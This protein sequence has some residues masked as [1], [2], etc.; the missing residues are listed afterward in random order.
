MSL[1][2]ELDQLK[3]SGLYRQLKTIEKINGNKVT[4]A[5]R[6]L[7]SFCSNDYL[8]LSQHPLV[9]EKANEAAK[10]FGFGA[11]A[12]RLISGQTIWHD[13]LEKKLA[14]F[15]S[16]AAALVFPSGYQANLGIISALVGTGDTVI[17]DR[18]CHASIIDAC[19]LSK[20]KLQVFPHQNMAALEKILG[21]SSS[22]KQKLIITDSVFSMDGDLANL[23]EIVGLAKKYGTLTMIDEAHATGVIGKT[24]RGLEEYFGVTGKVDLIMGTLSKALGS[25]GG[26]VSASQTIIDYLVNKSRPFI[27]STALPAAACAA[28]YTSLEIIENNPS[29][30][31]KLRKNISYLIKQLANNEINVKDHQTPIIPIMTYDP[32]KTL[33]ISHKL[34]TA[35]FLV[36]GIRPPAVPTGKCRLRITVN[37]NHTE[38]EIEGLAKMI[39]HLM[40]D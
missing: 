5:G 22:F 34:L 29:L 27:F 40:A 30:L 19:R 13:K 7:L 21:R 20:A 4:I 37:A 23:P 10:E 8:G 18:L 28:A 12:S 17:I 3:I 26:F 25:V 9:I 15:K 2:E 35:G 14:Q 33:A 16:R 11:G 6:E 32:A 36:V 38:E 39:F 31:K 1:A 24:G